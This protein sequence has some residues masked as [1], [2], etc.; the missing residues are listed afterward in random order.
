MYTVVV[1]VKKMRRKRSED[2]L[3][4]RYLLWCYKMTKEELERVDRKFTQ[5]KVDEFVLRDL[6][7][8]MKSLRGKDS[9][10]FLKKIEE[11]TEY[12]AKKKENADLEKFVDA[13]AKKRK[14]HYLYLE[15]RL[16]AIEK[17][18]TSFLGIAEL[19]KIRDFYDQ[20]MTRRILESREHT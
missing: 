6:N 5:L 7:G 9:E 4:R 14:P 1:T 2:N 18:I 13:S 16:S 15:K 17:A 10:E 11:F 8:Q 20:E 3:I 19:R 12:M